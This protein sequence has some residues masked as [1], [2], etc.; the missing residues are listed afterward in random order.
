MWVKHGHEVEHIFSFGITVDDGIGHH[1]IGKAVALNALSLFH[2]GACHKPKTY[3]GVIRP[4]RS[5]S[6]SCSS[7]DRQKRMC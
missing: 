6:D 4:L 2:H 3:F 5:H 7:G 1:K